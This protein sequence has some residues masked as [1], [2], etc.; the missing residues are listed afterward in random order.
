MSHCH[1]DFI[2]VNIFVEKIHGD[3]KN[4]LSGGWD[5]RSLSGL[6]FIL[7]VV[8]FFHYGHDLHAIGCAILLCCA[9]MVILLKP[10]KN[11]YVNYLDTLLLANYV[12]IILWYIISAR[13]AFSMVLAKLLFTLPMAIFI[14]GIILRKWKSIIKPIRFIITWA[15]YSIKQGIFYQDSQNNSHYCSLIIINSTMLIFSV[16]LW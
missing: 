7:R 5:M 14:L 16:C 11:S 15:P 9:L 4:G 12:L 10:Y 8:L 2:A 1:L 3:Y 13:L 6:Y